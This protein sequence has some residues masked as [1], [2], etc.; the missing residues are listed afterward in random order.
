MLTNRIGDY[1]FISQGKT[2]IPGVNDGEEMEAT[3]VS[4][5]ER[6]C[7][8]F[9]QIFTIH[10]RLH[11]DLKK[12]KQFGIAKKFKF[13]SFFWMNL[14]FENLNENFERILS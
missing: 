7:Q 6:S 9:Q 1:F 14:K 4:P 3:D 10:C 8:K 11:H 13:E 5:P 2:R 12:K